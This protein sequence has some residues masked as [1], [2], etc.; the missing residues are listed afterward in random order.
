[1]VGA[2]GASLHSSRLQFQ[3][4]TVASMLLG[5]ASACAAC[6]QSPGVLFAPHPTPALP[7]PAVPPAACCRINVEVWGPL[8]E[9]ASQ[10][11]NGGDRVAVQV[12][13]GAQLSWAGCHRAARQ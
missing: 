9:R 2:L 12:G 8:A 1:M 7:T 13:C 4:A 6:L 5:V 10:E 3:C 11:L